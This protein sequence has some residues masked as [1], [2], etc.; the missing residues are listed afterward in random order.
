MFRGSDFVQLTELTCA[1]GTNPEKWPAV[2][3]R[4]GHALDAPA[5]ALVVIDVKQVGGTIVANQGIPPDLERAYN[6]YYAERNEWI[7]RGQRLQVPGRVRLSEESCPEDELVKTEFY[8]DFLRSLGARHAIGATILKDGSL[9]A[10]VTALR[11][12]RAS[13]FGRE[14]L[15]VLSAVIPHLRSAIETHRRLAGARLEERV[16][17]D[18]LDR[19]AAGVILLDGSGRTVFVNAEARRILEARDGLVL[20][21]GT[22]STSRS[23]ETQMLRA[24]IA[25]AAAPGGC[26]GQLAL[27]RPSLRRPLGVDIVPLAIPAEDGLTARMAAVFIADPERQVEEDATLVARLHGLTPAESE[28]AARLVVGDTLGDAAERR[29]I[30]RETARTHLKRILHKT[31]AKNQADFVRR[32][33]QGPAR[34]ARRELLAGSQLRE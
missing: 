23:R 15:R 5:L 27:G 21:R 11:G 8:N 28:L 31:G 4:L 14:G 2:L 17:L 25:S 1:A 29:G 10:N 20:D 26:G 19:L 30:T 9:V 33:L 3:D 32:V 6:E 22:I 18:A 12:K 7:I 34:M 13:A 16:V 24:L